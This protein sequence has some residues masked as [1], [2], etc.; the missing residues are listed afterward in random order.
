MG[1]GDET[2]QLIS[3]VVSRSATRPTT[4]PARQSLRR[5]TLLPTAAVV[6]M[7]AKNADVVRIDRTQLACRPKNDTDC[8]AQRPPSRPRGHWTVH[9]RTRRLLDVAS[10]WPVAGDVGSYR[11][12]S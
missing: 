9:G 4:S 1:R 11:G 6:I 8:A 3:R 12:T 7:Q 2:R 10:T 5:G